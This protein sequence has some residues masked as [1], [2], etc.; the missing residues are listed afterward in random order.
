MPTQIGLL[1]PTRRI[2][3]VPNEHSLLWLV[4][5]VGQRLAIGRKP[6]TVNSGATVEFGE[7]GVV[8]Q[9]PETHEVVLTR[10]G[11]QLAV[12]AERHVPDAFATMRRQRFT[13]RLSAGHTPRADLAVSA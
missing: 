11:E 5:A 13:D 2:S 1:F 3:N 8:R 6:N 10:G 7:W 12:R 4:A 9:V